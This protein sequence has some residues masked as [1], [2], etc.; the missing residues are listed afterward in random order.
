M[1]EQKST[2]ERRE[3]HFKVELERESEQESKK[4]QK[5]SLKEKSLSNKERCNYFAFDDSTLTHSL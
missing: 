4:M 5:L 1:R 2:F 3:K